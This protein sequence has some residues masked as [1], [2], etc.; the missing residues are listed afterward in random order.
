MRPLVPQAELGAGRQVGCSR[1]RVPASPLSQETTLPEAGQPSPGQGHLW[2]AACPVSPLRGSRLTSWAFGALAVGQM[3]TG[4]PCSVPA[5]CPSTLRAP[6]GPA[7][8]LPSSRPLCW[9]P[10]H[11]GGGPLPA[12]LERCGP[13]LADP[14]S[15]LPP[16]WAPLS[17]PRGAEVAGPG[18]GQCALPRPAP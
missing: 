16:K 1:G 18:P 9:H 12:L 8:L 5:S 11:P 15:L 10:S 4:G 3:L 13:A 17:A 2:P 14:G 6:H 7:L